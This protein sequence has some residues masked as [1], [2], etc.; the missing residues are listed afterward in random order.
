VI[1]ERRGHIDEKFIAAA[2]T[3]WLALG[4]VLYVATGEQAHASVGIGWGLAGAM[5]AL[6]FGALFWV[7]RR[8]MRDL[9]IVVLGG[10]LVRLVVLAVALAAMLR[11]GVDPMRFTVG[12]FTAYLLL[13]TLEVAWLDAHGRRD[14]RAHHARGGAS[15]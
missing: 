6:T 15:A 13:Q 8:S 14:R 1:V 10:F 11:A 4:A 7:R 5:S 3:A 9:M 12:F 2:A